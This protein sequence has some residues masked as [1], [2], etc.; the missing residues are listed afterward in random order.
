[1][2]VRRFCSRLGIPHSTWYY[3]RRR[4]R[5][6][7]TVR[8]WPAPVVDRIEE[9]AAE[10]ATAHQAWGHRKIAAMMKADGVAVS[11]SSVERALRRRGLLLPARYL[12]ERRENA[13]RRKERFL[14]P[15][16]RRNRV[17]QMDFSRFETAAGGTWNIAAV[18]DYATKLCVTAP[19]TGTQGA[20][21][22]VRALEQAVREAERLLGRP[23]IEDCVDP[24]TGELEHLTIVTD[25]GPAYKSDRFIRFIMSRPEL[26]HVRTRHYSP[27]QNGVVERFY[28]TLKY[29]HLYQL[30]IADAIELD[31]QI[32][33]HRH[34]YN[35]IRPHESL[36][37]V[38]PMSVYLADPNLLEAR[39]V[40]ES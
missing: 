34:I 11:P 2:A 32:R 20:I 22:A 31:E 40:Q 24:T 3:W 38:T 33:V 39:S 15:P 25:N 5:Q 18:V 13:R 28:R 10:T 12:A 19:V 1:V 30:E 14:V 8:R 17:W 29:E 7:R 21:D 4:Y 36:G 37:Q 26:E 6:G 16:T 23:L 9:H 35:E 27:G